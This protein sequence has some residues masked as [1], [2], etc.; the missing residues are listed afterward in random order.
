MTLAAETRPASSASFRGFCPRALDF[1]SALENHNDRDWFR[2]HELDYRRLITEPACALI[3]SL[4][5][6]LRS[7]LGA[8]LRARAAS[9]PA[10][11][12]ASPQP[13][14]GWERD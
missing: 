1:L 13:P 2:Q 10:T 3:T 8:Q 11:S 12:C 14:T 9:I 7:Q 6:L 4:A 5:P